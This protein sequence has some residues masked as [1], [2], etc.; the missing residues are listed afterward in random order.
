MALMNFASHIVPVQDWD[1]GDEESA[2]IFTP[3]GQFLFI[4]FWAAAVV[5]YLANT[6]LGRKSLPPED[7]SGLMGCALVGSLVLDAVVLFIAFVIQAATNVKI[8]PSVITVVL[9]AAV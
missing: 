7:W 9:V 2:A 5:F 6:N 3:V 4:G 1:R 8:E